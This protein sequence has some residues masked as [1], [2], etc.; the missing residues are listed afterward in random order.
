MWFE[1]AAAAGVPQAMLNLGKMFEQVNLRI[2][3]LPVRLTV[4]PESKP[5]HNLVELNSVIGVAC[6][7]SKQ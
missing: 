6:P 2:I 3:I 4:D 5:I 7:L 1:R